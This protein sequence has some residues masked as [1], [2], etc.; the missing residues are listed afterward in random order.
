MVDRAD[1]LSRLL[2]MVP[3]SGKLDDYR[4][5]LAA[6]WRIAYDRSPPGEIPYH[7]VL[8]GSVVLD[9]PGHRPAQRL[10]AGDIV[11]L[12]DVPRM[13]C[14]TAAARPHCPFASA[15]PSI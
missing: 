2:E 7:I 14:T 8:E 1:W 11:L 12:N 3:L 9:E 10:V 6:P 15:P 13:R 5:F 4:S